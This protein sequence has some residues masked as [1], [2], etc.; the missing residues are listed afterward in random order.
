MSR[1][2]QVIQ[3]T[4]PQSDHSAAFP[5]GTVLLCKGVSVT[6]CGQG[7]SDSQWK[8]PAPSRSSNRGQLSQVTF[9]VPLQRIPGPRP[10]GT[11]RE[12]ALLPHWADDGA[13]AW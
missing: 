13:E 10:Q 4:F 12:Q 2:R 7:G 3:L 9:K 11:G 8:H 1:P 6:H 5:L